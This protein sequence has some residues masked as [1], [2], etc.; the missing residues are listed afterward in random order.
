MKECVFSNHVKFRHIQAQVEGISTFS[1][2]TT[3]RAT[4]VDNRI[5]DGLVARRSMTFKESFD[6]DFVDGNGE[7][8]Q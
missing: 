5:S 4:S 1:C 6:K 2:F 8:L 7:L 3:Q